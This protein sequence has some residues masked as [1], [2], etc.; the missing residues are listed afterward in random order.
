MIFKKLNKKAQDTGE[1]DS[2]HGMM[3]IVIIILAVLMLI[4]GGFFIKKIYDKQKVI[5]EEQRCKDAVTKEA[6]LIGMS[7]N[8]L[9]IANDFVV[10][11]N[12]P[13]NI[14]KINDNSQLNIKSK[15]AN[16]MR[17]CWNIWLEGKPEMFKEKDGTFCHV[18][19]FITFKEKNKTIEGFT[20]YLANVN[21]PNK[22]ITFSD[23]FAGYSTP[24]SQRY[25]ADHPITVEAKKLDTLNTNN[26]Y[27][28][29]F[30][31][32]KG[33]ESLSRFYT[34]TLD[35][36]RLG[37]FL[38]G[39][40]AGVVGGFLLL[41]VASG[42]GLPVAVIGGAAVVVISGIKLAYDAIFETT[43]AE[44][45]SGLFIVEYNTQ[46]IKDLGCE[47]IATQKEKV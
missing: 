25:L 42:V 1:D 13:T 14:V 38:A 9:A 21:M 18:C 7:N 11:I 34:N 39:T 40:G 33:S 10:K 41:A 17:R 36:S 47:Y 44:W 4:I 15:I 23:Y 22:K 12:C 6:L 8:Y 2:G 37:F 30:V 43:D 28:V 20:E 3:F 32:A 31:Y 5:E 29:I 35:K 26:D 19:S 45:A 16:E 46:N 24:Q 27:G